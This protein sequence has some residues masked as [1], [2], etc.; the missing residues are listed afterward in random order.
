MLLLQFRLEGDRY[1]IDASSVVEVLPLLEITR[2]PQAPPEIAGVC[3]RRGT[4]VPVVD[5]SQLL[6][7]RPA[8][9]RLSTRI[10][11]VHYADASGTTRQLGLIAEN[12]TDV[13]QRETTAFVASGITNH[14]TPYLGDVAVDAGGM[15]QRLDVG[16]LLP[17]SLQ[18]ILF[19]AA[20][21]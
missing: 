21:A 19:G 17:P 8:A 4:P 7:G 9:R 2:V 12:A 13:I 10:L 18:Q 20:A 16:T 3:D 15:V 14:R 5:L 1:A 6:L 11:I